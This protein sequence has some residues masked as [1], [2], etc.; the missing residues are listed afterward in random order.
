M[1]PLPSGL[2]PLARECVRR[3]PRT[4]L[5]GA[6]R[7]PQRR[8]RGGRDHG[9]VVDPTLGEIL[10]AAGYD[11]TFALLVPSREPA[12]LP[13]PVRRD[14]W[15]EVVI[16]GPTVTVPRGAS[17]DLG[18]TGK[19]YAADLVASVVVTELD[20]PVVVSVGGDVR[21]DGPADRST[22]WPVVVNHTVADYTD[23]TGATQ[24]VI[25][26]VGGLATSSVAARRWVRGGREWHHLVDPRT[27]SPALGPWRSVSATG[28]T[29]VAAN[30]ASTAAIVLGDDAPAWL[31]EHQVC[32]RL[33]DTDG[34]IVTT[35][36]WPHEA[37]SRHTGVGVGGEGR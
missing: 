5:G 34:R 10:V 7:R 27:G 16:D 13:A 22:S 25:V 6:D 15:R 26:D 3:A 23:G 21:V 1:Q 29:C 14:L 12:A 24:T 18:A 17:L 8:P 33:V 2:R 35:G 19:A 4:R 11:R 20:T 36:G 28:R 37:R 30:T 32:A 31:T 9:G